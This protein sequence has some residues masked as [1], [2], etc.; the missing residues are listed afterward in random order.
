MTQP[1]SPTLRRA[2]KTDSE[3]SASA[4]E[5]DGILQVFRRMTEEMSASSEEF[6]RRVAVLNGEISALSAQRMAE[7]KEKERL[8]DQLEGL[9]RILPTGVIVIDR[10]GRIQRANPA[11]E[12]LLVHDQL[13]TLNGVVWAKVIQVA[14]RPQEHDGHEISLHNGRLVSLDTC[15]LEGFGQLVV[16][17]DLTATRRLQAEVSRHQRLAG[18][19]RMVASMAHQI[20]TPLSAAMLYTENLRKPGISEQQRQRFAEKVQSR[21]EHLEQQVRDML[22]FA[23]G[24]SKLVDRS[25]TGELLQQLRSSCAAAME[26]SSSQFNVLNEAPEALIICNRDTLVSAFSNLIN[27]AIDAVGQNAAIDLRV[28]QQ[29]DRIVFDF[30]DHGPGIPDEVLRQLGE[31]FVTTKANGTGLGLP[32]VQAVVRSHQ[33]TFQLSNV[34]GGTLARI[35]LPFQTLT[36]ASS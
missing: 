2:K 10:S 21:L 23:K 19:G 29:Q 16:L 12:Q 4:H 18:M 17:H 15:A 25:L 20:R 34:D 8:A 6:E 14:F 24:D 30:H 36:E 28:Y 32:V 7:L 9:L 22:L 27:N 3:K 31:L 35:S 1:V 13:P 5:V 33:G 26:R 11:A